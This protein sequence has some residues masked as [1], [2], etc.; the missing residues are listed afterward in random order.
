MEGPHKIPHSPTVTVFDNRTPDGRPLRHR[1]TAPA[2]GT[3]S[4]EVAPAL[5]AIGVV[6]ARGELHRVGLVPRH[7][8]AHEDATAVDNAT[9][10]PRSCG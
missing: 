5:R 6:M 4:R 2:A 10:K 8:G 7:I 1:P 9:S 3:V